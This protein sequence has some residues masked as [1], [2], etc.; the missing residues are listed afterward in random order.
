VRGLEAR[1]V[2]RP[3]DRVGER[4]VADLSLDRRPARVPGEGQGQDV[5]TA[6]ERGQNEL[7]G[8]PG[9]GEAVEAYQ[10]RPGASA[11]RWGEGRG[12]APDATWGSAGRGGGIPL[13]LRSSVQPAVAGES[14]ANPRARMIVWERGAA[15]RSGGRR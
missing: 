4:G 7:P 12:Q 13:P 3:L 14:S 9:V 2:D 11:V 5:V 15:H 8:A 1:L 10:R 6:L